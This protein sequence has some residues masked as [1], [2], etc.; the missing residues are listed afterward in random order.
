MNLIIEMLNNFANIT[1]SLK[2]SAFIAFNYCVNVTEDNKI[3][4]Q[5]KTLYISNLVK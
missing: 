5:L 2:A 4:K 1:K 3:L